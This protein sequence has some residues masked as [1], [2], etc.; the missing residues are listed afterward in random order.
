M[1]FGAKGIATPKHHFHFMADEKRATLVKASLVRVPYVGMVSCTTKCG[2]EREC[3]LMLPEGE[4]QYKCFECAKHYLDVKS[5][6]KYD[7]DETT[8]V[9]HYQ[10]GI[11]R[12]KKAANCA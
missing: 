7:G 5:F 3:E 10:L 2:R 11:T 6:V 9:G 4:A 8:V 1:G 12:I